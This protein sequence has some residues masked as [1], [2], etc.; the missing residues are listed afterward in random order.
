MRLGITVG[1]LETHDIVSLRKGEDGSITIVVNNNLYKATYQRTPNGNFLLNSTYPKAEY[2]RMAR[3]L[4][5]I[6]TEI[7]RRCIELSE[8]E[9]R[10]DY[11]PVRID[12]GQRISVG[13]SNSMTIY[14]SV[15]NYV[16]RALF[17]YDGKKV[18]FIRSTYPPEEGSKISEIIKRNFPKIVEVMEQYNMIEPKATKSNMG[19]RL[20]TESFS[21]CMTESGK[22]EREKV[23]NL[24]EKLFNELDSKEYSN[25]EIQSMLMESVFETALRYRAKNK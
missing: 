14:I 22:R 4:N 12:E 10:I 23:D 17:H 19:T 24:V 20:Y 15:E 1:E 6:E 21:S 2:S 8:A 25:L 18:K 11:K 7:E 5:S 3:A 9:L 16:H 13:Q